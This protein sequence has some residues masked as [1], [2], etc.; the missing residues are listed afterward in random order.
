M[1]EKGLP[2]PE[3]INGDLKLYYES[4]GQGDP[5]ILIRGLGS[6]ADHWYAQVPDL[7]ALW[8]VIVFDNRGIARSGDPGGDFSI[9]DMVEDTAALMDGL[10]IEQ[11]HVLGLSMGGMIAQELAIAHPGRVRSLILVVT[12]CGGR[13]AI[14]PA[15]E[16][17]EIMQRMIAEN[18]DE[19]R[20]AALPV[21]FGPRTLKDFPE[22]I[23]KYA[24]ISMNHPAG[25]GI[26]SRQI[27]AISGHDTYDRLP[28]ITSPALVMTGA[29]DVL[30]PPENSKI[31]AE[32]I[33][34][35][36]L[37]VIAHGGHQVLIEEPREC[38]SLIIDFLHQM[39]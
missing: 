25:A 27:K 28:K 9:R 29:Q 17:T 15:A 11:A 13:H 1:P 22:V 14:S 24:E 35:A 8:R 20:L 7:S 32:R 12:H 31:L 18:S 26:L 3:M 10:G 5:L 30:I 2:M 19:A 21:F 36:Q 23:E 33:A 6:N 37:R 38:N 39:K 4:H 34:G 16:V